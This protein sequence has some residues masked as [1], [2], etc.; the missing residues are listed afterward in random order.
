M[1]TDKLE[2]HRNCTTS[3][4]KRLINVKEYVNTL[5]ATLCPAQQHVCILLTVT[6]RSESCF[7]SS[8]ASVWIIYD[9]CRKIHYI[10]ELLPVLTPACCM[11][12]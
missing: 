5:L 12:V 8:T 4:S 10:E 9:C 2:Q 6:T 1:N 11:L 7:N 3:I